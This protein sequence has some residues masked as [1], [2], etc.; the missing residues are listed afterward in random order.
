MLEKI[1]TKGHS[2]HFTA[3]QGQFIFLLLK[4]KNLSFLYVSIFNI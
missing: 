4:D 1:A 2:P 3:L